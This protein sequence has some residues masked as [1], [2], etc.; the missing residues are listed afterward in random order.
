MNI[1]SKNPNFA[2]LTQNTQTTMLPALPRTLEKREAKITPLVE[3]YFLEKYPFSVLVEIKATKT[4]TIPFSAVKSHQLQSLKQVR[5][6]VGKAHKMSD[7]GRVQQPADFW[8]FKNA[9]SFVVACFLKE[10]VCLAINPYEWNGA[11][12][13]SDC[14][15]RFDI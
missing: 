14:E 10:R 4:N 15:F 3:K 12:V 6:P 7:I 11:R 1:L 8:M 2:S 13:D 9:Q 5:T